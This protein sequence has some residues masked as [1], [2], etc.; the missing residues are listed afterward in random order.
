MA[1]VF[2]VGN[3]GQQRTPPLPTQ[4]RYEHVGTNYA[5]VSESAHAQMLNAGAVDDTRRDVCRT[6]TAVPAFPSS[7]TKIRAV[8]LRRA[9]RAT[10]ELISGLCSP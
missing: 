5:D 3:V 6:L 7:N 1:G 4:R 2:V 8:K 9:Y 10:Q